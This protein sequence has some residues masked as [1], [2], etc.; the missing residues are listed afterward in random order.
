[1]SDQG[2]IPQ[3]SYT[4]AQA[5]RIS[6]IGK[7]MLYDLIAQGRIDKIKIGSKTLIPAKSLHAL[8]DTAATGSAEV[9]PLKNLHG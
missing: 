7:T 6:G 3:I 4:V 5:C 9:R 1:M 2:R 8:I